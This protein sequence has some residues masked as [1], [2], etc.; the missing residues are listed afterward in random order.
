[1]PPRQ[2]AATRPPGPKATLVTARSVGD[3]QTRSPPAPTVAGWNVWGSAYGG[4]GHLNGDA[5]VVGS[6]DLSTSAGG[7]AAGA[8]RFVT[9]NT[10]VGFAR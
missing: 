7:F 4:A 6:H 10:R 5:A 9:P 8:D 1:M 2:P 3:D